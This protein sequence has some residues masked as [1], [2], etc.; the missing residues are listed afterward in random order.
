VIAVHEKLCQRL[1]E[2]NS[3]RITWPQAPLTTDLGYDRR[4]T[5]IIETED[6]KTWLITANKGDK[7]TYHRG[8]LARDRRESRNGTR[9]GL[10]KLATYVMDTCCTWDVSFDK[11]T[12]QTDSDIILKNIISL[13]Q[14]VIRRYKG[15][16]GQKLMDCEYIATKI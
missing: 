13:T 1:S 6:F 11:K 5:M 10:D 16:K 2:F 12:K 15:D 7:F 3:T 14:K 4:I 9:T 8:N